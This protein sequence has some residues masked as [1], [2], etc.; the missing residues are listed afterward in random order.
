MN[1]CSSHSVFTLLLFAGPQ[2]KLYRGHV[3]TLGRSSE[4]SL[5]DEELVSMDVEGEYDPKTADGEAQRSHVY[6]ETVPCPRVQHTSLVSRD[7]QTSL[8]L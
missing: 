5:Y 3:Y 8:V 7:R 6:W 2:L 4:R 1:S